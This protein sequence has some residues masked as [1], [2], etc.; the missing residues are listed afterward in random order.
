MATLQIQ[1]LGDITVHVDGNPIASFR[2]R[3]E[4]HLLAYLALHRGQ[5]QRREWLWSLF[6]PDMP[7]PNSRDNLNHALSR[8]RHSLGPAA[9]LLPKSSNNV[10]LSDEAVVDVFD[11]LQAAQRQ[12]TGDL[13]AAAALWRGTP[14]PS[15]Y[16][17]W[18]QEARRKLEM[19][20]AKLLHR[21]VEQLAAEERV[22]EAL[23]YARVLASMEPYDDALCREVMQLAAKAGRVWDGLRHY[24]EFAD[25]LR[26]NLDVEPDPETRAVRAELARIQEH[27]NSLRDRSDLLALQP[28]TGFVGRRREF[29]ALLTALDRA[30]SGRGSTVLITGE[31]GIG[32][33]R[34]ATE[35]AQAAERHGICVVHSRAWS[36]HDS[37]LYMLWIETLRRLLT[38][39]TPHTL[40]RIDAI[41]L[42]HLQLLLPEIRTF[43]PQL[44]S[45]PPQLHALNNTALFEAVRRV[46]AA[47]TQQHPVVLI[48][49]DVQWGQPDDLHLLHY[50]AK[51][52]AGERLL[53]LALYREEETRANSVLEDVTHSLVEQGAAHEI[54]LE[55]LARHDLTTLLIHLER[56][57]PWDDG[58]EPSPVNVTDAAD[59]GDIAWLRL[60]VGQ[61]IERANGNPFFA[62][63]LFHWLQTG[64]DAHTVPNSVA[65]LTQERLNRLLPRTRQLVRLAAVIGRSFD[66]AL[67][68]RAAGEDMLTILQCLEEMQAVGLV[69]AAGEAYMFRHD[70]L[71]D[72]IYQD[73]LG[74]VR[75]A[76]HGQ[77]AEQLERMV[78]QPQTAR[79]GTDLGALRLQALAYH[80]WQSEQ[81]ERAIP[82]IEQAGD[83][84]HRLRAN[85][86]AVSCYQALVDWLEGL[87]HLSEAARVREKLGTLLGVLTRYQEARETLEMA[88]AYYKAA[89][90]LEGLAHIAARLGRVYVSQGAPKEGR[91]RVL[92]LLKQIEHAEGLEECTESL[93]HAYATLAGLLHGA[94][95]YQQ[96]QVAAQRAEELAHRVKDRPAHMQ[97]LAEALN[98]HGL[99]LINLGHLA[100]GCQ[101]L[102]G[103]ISTAETVDDLL[104]LCEALNNAAWAYETQGDF[105]KSKAYL[106][107][108][109]AVA[110]RRGDRADVVFMTQGLGRATF[111]LGQWEMARSYLQRAAAIS[112]EAG[113]SWASPYPPLELGRLSLAEGDWDAAAVHLQECL[114]RARENGDMQALRSA[115]R[116][117]AQ[118]DIMT[119]R[120]EAARARLEPL[121]QGPRAADGDVIVLL[122]TLAWAQLEMNN[123]G[124]AAALLRKAVDRAMAAGNQ[125]ALLDALHVQA[126]VAIARKRWHDAAQALQRALALARSMP[127]LY[128]EASML[129]THGELLA[130]QGQREKAVQ[131]LSEALAI[132]RRLGAVKD[133]E[134]TVAAIA[135]LPRTT[136]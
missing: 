67:L 84:A 38:A 45:L 89:N 4:L 120:P 110:E 91:D 75:R 50:L 68:A 21:L 136:S 71:R 72:V 46:V 56:G 33:S 37:P 40:D 117:L 121:V 57:A 81:P 28:S 74:P 2:I 77:V 51:R 65:A 88:A 8:L 12:R 15:I 70:V 133:A 43:R 127:Y 100:E 90:N 35:L 5:R 69:Q 53:I 19:Q 36:T 9:E 32:K 128:A 47:V 96:E 123:S 31:A 17:E 131:Q 83:V 111:R 41:W 49:D 66:P 80:F 94:G 29:H 109:L 54:R 55:R 102:E 30:I 134:R 107:R 103:A 99:A 118:R 22:M 106:E 116:L 10:W 85:E 13:L 132:F 23:Q 34:L 11:F 58:Q 97:L 108:A 112:R 114:D 95:D 39:L 113:R 93:A 124:Q 119:G 61:V 48:L 101:L 76:L 92:G 1:L 73:L 59:H 42:E 105:Q 135:Q 129:Y 82:Y 78:L 18:A 122:P 60:P 44:R 64:G 86:T 24:E 87:G 79:D 16:T 20:Y 26:R 104:T 3:K 130:H 125:L 7:E 52:T 62:I 126:R 98:E 25:H 115:Q 27:G 6:W 63:E 14:L